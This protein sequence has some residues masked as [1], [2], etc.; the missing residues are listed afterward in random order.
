MP[1]N[2][3]GREQARLACEFVRAE[4]QLQAAWSSDLRR[5]METADALGMPVTTSR[6]LREVDYGDWEGRRFADLS[7]EEQRHAVGRTAWDPDFSAPGGEKFRNLVRRGERFIAE[8]G[9]LDQEGD[10]VIV[11]HGGS[12]RGL[13][14]GLLGLP[15]AALGRFYFSNGGVS[16][17]AADNEMASLTAFNITSHLGDARPMY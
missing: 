10:I 17:V 6:Q 16:V 3:K 8:S 5:C 12:L 11:G 2:E 4:F 15:D 9:V 7:S 14:V 13:L 1:L